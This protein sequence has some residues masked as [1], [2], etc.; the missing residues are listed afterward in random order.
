MSR[1]HNNL[2]NLKYL[3]SDFFDIYFSELAQ[4]TPYK[5][6]TDTFSHLL[7]AFIQSD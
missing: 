2:K 1:W 3:F 7:D 5:K 4:F 6:I